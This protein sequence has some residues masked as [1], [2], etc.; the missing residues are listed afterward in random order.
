MKAAWLLFKLM[1]FTFLFTNTINTY[2]QTFTLD[3]KSPSI[4]CLNVFTILFHPVIQ[5]V[6]PSG[7]QEP[8]TQ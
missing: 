7:S 6:N 2:N 3:S 1:S 4:F 5:V 8:H